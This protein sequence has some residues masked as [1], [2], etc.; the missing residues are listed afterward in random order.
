LILSKSPRKGRCREPGRPSTGIQAWQSIQELYAKLAYES[1]LEVRKKA[2]YAGNGF[3]DP[4]EQAV[5]N[6]I[7]QLSG[8]DLR[9]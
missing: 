9:T 8:T 4:L 1:V 5:D 2:F 7:Y 3:A 6:R